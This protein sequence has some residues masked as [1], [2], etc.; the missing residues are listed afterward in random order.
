MKSVFPA[1]D[2]PQTDVIVKQNG[3]NLISHRAQKKVFTKSSC[4]SPE[5]Q[6]FLPFTKQTIRSLNFFGKR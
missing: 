1:V 2:F 6:Q 5:R 3:S 4:D